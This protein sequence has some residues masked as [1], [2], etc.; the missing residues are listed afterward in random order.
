MSCKRWSKTKRNAFNKVRVEALTRQSHNFVDPH[1]IASYPQ[2][3]RITG[4]LEHSLA[5]QHSFLHSVGA[6]G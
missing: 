5:L 4:L 2:A 6:L 1:P 3:V